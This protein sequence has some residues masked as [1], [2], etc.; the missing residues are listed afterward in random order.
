MTEAQIIP[1]DH[2]AAWKATDFA[3]KDALAV[4]L[5][6]R[7]LDALMAATAHLKGA[8]ADFSAVTPTDFPLGA[9]EDDVAAWRHEVREGR[10]ILLLRG[11]PVEA[12][13]LEDLRLLYLGLGSHFG[14][15]VSQSALGDFVGDVVNIGDKDKRERAYRN[16]RELN[17]HTDRC[18]LVAMLCIRPAVEGGLSGYASALT[19][20]N[21]MLR[22]RPDLLAHLY[23]G[24]FHHRFGEQP[25][26]EPLVTTERIPTF[27]IANG[28]PSV[29]YI[30]GYIDLAVE[31]GH[32]SLSDTELE[33]LDYFDQVGNR[34][35][36]RP[37]LRLEPGEA[38]FT[39]NCLLLHTRTAFEDSG[40]P[41]LKRH[42]L[43][44]WLREDGRPMAPGVVLHKGSAGIEK[45]ARKGTYYTPQPAS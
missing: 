19:I 1:F 36:I 26:G 9:I 27:S 31:E 16:S 15:P 43:R 24:Y 4:D 28:I 3:S 10:G 32:V 23:R 38:S 13:D 21:E 11:L 12:I 17:L 2:P 34:P 8:T 7:H 14:R 30:R 18:D 44:L 37:N 39:N 45:R 40:D 35:D 29:I 25:P 41:A 5:D 20:H 33:A 22:E 42:L 6:R